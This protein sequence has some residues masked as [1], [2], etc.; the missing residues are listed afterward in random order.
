MPP[1]P[2]AAAAQDETAVSSWTAARKWC[3]PEK[4]AGLPDSIQTA[5]KAAAGIELADCKQL[6]ITATASLGSPVC[7]TWH[8]QV[9]VFNPCQSI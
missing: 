2:Q 6:C 1:L 5:Y 4:V 8:T 3:S 9:F 7:V